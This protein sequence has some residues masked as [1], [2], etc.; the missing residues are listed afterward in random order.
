MT[1]SRRVALCG[2]S[3]DPPHT[4]HV[5]TVAYGL[6]ACPIDEIWM[7]PVWKHAFAKPLSPYEDRRAMLALALDDFGPRV[8]ISDVERELDGTSRTID[9]VRH[10]RAQHPDTRFSLLMGT[11]LFAERERWKAFDELERLVDMHVV[12]RSGVPDPPD[13]P[14]GPHLP[15]IS[16]T[17]IRRRVR[18]GEPL[19]GLVPLA[20]A[21]YIEQNGLYR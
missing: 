7:V 9:T 4:A 18:A 6:S 8:R 12:G 17:E 5:L 14:V 3:F 16:S 15:P 20:V 1:E 11:D 2:G 19:H 21:E 10:L 13:V